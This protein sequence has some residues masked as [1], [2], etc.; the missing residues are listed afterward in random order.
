MIQN[1]LK[2]SRPG[3]RLLALA[4]G[5]TTAL[6][7]TGVSAAAAAEH[8]FAGTCSL[9]GSTVFES[10]GFLSGR[11][12]TTMRGPCTGSFDG[13]GIQVRQVRFVT[14]RSSGIDLGITH[15]SGRGSGRMTLGRVGTPLRFR[16]DYQGLALVLHGSRDSSAG[17]TLLTRRGDHIEGQLATLGTLY[18]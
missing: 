13:S 12:I 8:S 14:V 2:R 16:V 3:R 6:A 15:G 7:F 10:S 1:A 18:G 9:K 4:L 5:A 17:L 11:L